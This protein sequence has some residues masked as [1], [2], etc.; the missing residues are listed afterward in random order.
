MM[1]KEK[2]LALVTAISASLVLSACVNPFEA[3]VHRG[4]KG[5]FNSAN[6][7]QSGAATS[8]NI[9]DELKEVLALMQKETA[10]GLTKEEYMTLASLCEEKGMMKA[11][12]DVL[13]DAYRI[14]QDPEILEECE[15]IS[16]NGLE[17]S[18]EVIALL[19]AVLTGMSTGTG[20]LSEAIDAIEE[21]KS[22][23]TLMPKLKEGRRTYFYEEDSEPYF[24]LT[25]GFNENG[26]KT[27]EAYFFDK[28][29]KTCYVLTKVSNSV[30][31]Y[32]E[33]GEFESLYDVFNKASSSTFEKL[34]VDSYS[35][36]MKK[37]TGSLKDGKLFG[38]YEVVFSYFDNY[39]KDKTSVLIKNQEDFTKVVFK[40]TFDEN[41]KPTVEALS[42]KNIEKLVKTGDGKTAIAYAYTEDLQKCLFKEVSA[43]EKDNVFFEKTE[44]SI[45]SYPKIDRYDYAKAI[46]NNKKL[47]DARKPATK[48]GDGEQLVKIVDSKIFVCLDGEWIEYGNLSD[49]EGEDPFLKYNQKSDGVI[50]NVNTGTE[51][52]IVKE[53]ASI[54]SNK[55][56]ETTKNTTTGKTQTGTSKPATGTK[57]P[58]VATPTPQAPTQT[59]APAPAPAAQPAQGSDSGSGGGSSDHSDSHE[60]GSSGGSQ[61]STPDPGP[62]GG[63]SGGGSGDSGGGSSSGDGGDIDFG[64]WSGDD[65]D[66]TD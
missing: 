57:K 42:D 38:D 65:S 6:D 45:P 5:L 22:F 9:D 21:D 25:V 48:V 4:D 24:V 56:E 54:D 64:D 28:N 1:K 13:E 47:L 46:E 10:E 35:G 31:Y 51:S 7:N 49:I 26:E 40:G 41:G 23:E 44:L 58:V 34:T 32:K 20:D 39:A 15:D 2:A 59:P 60:S 62:S 53:V 14:F 37:E 36:V 30:T 27:L 55:V 29:T 50:T 66:S 3:T 43:D 33:A 11:K 19:D 17:E 52:N 18:D 61:P 12:R 63:D 8:T 16:V